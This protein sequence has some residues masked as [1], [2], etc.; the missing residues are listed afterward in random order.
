MWKIVLYD[1]NIYWDD[2]SKLEVLKE[3][4]NEPSKE[5]LL[6]IDGNK[7]K[8]CAIDYETNLF[9]VKP[10]S[11][12]D[13]DDLDEIDETD[14]ENWTCPFCGY[15]DHDAF[16]CPDNDER[17]CPGCQSVVEH[18]RVVTYSY[19]VTPVKKAKVQQY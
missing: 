2:K 16:E 13:E 8:W 5:S 14:E 12:T 17:N 6:D 18:E 9:A 10:V 7:F 1:I 4:P 11:I 3:V 15:V 19:I